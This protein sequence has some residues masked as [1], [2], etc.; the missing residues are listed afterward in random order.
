MLYRD[1][2]DEIVSK[3]ANIRANL[4]KEIYEANGIYL[5][6]TNV[7]IEYRNYL[8]SNPIV[9]NGD[10]DLPSGPS[11]FG[12]SETSPFGPP[13][14]GTTDDVKLTVIRG[15][16]F[17][18][19]GM[20]ACYGKLYVNGEYWFDTGERNI[21]PPGT[22]KVA[23]RQ[24]QGSYKTG[25]GDWLKNGAAGKPNYRFAAYSNGYVPLILNVPG[26]SGIR[27]HQGTSVAWSE[28][29]LITGNFNNGKLANSWEC[30]KKLYDYCINAKSVNI[31]YQG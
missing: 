9:I 10:N 28:G 25:R 26:R 15:Q 5:G 8:S 4:I 14:V 22:Y 18:H 23:F 1:K 24:D 31:E 20:K 13:G 16:K 2:S 7:P 27:I 11:E 3:L 19:N 12:P 30:W 17:T 6:K 29:C 21:I